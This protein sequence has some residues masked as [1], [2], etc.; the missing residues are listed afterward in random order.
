MKRIPKDF[1]VHPLR[2]AGQRQKATD[3]KKC[4]TCSLWWDD[5]N[6]TSITPT[7]AGRCPFEAFH[8]CAEYHES[9]GK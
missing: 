2:T 7:P 4:G 3:P 9:G 5:A 6:I 1:P 8:I